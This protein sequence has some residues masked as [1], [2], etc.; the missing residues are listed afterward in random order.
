MPT[1]SPSVRK[2]ASLIYHFAERESKARYK[3]S[4]LGWFWSFMNPLTT[5]LVYGFVFGVVYGAEAPPTSN[6]NAENFGLYLFT[7]L[8]VWSVF[9]GVVNG[10]MGWLIGVSDLRKK[11]Y[12][13]TET[14]LLGGAAANAVQTLLEA[15]VLIAIMLV[16]ANISW[17]LIFLFLA[18]TFSM[19]FG[20]GVGFI[21]SVFNARYRDTQYLIGILLNVAFFGV[22]IV[23][24]QKLL[25]DG[26]VDGF[27]RVVLDWNPPA[28][29]VE[30]SRDAVYFLEVPQWNRLLAAAAW[31]I[32]TF[33]VGWV[34][35]RDQSM[36]ISE[37]P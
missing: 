16:L 3:R 31:G 2:S 15:V 30:I 24:T 6:G 1:L 10:S 9:T 8:I 21:V 34:Y 19:L 33:A 29:F 28:L 11:I 26:G 4:L 18:L 36:A 17:T 5:V 23:Y 32:I 14:A 37:E 25:D 20:L 35:F 13:P 12:F 27:L 7:G 22:P